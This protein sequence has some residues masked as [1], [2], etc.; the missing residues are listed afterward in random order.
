MA[1]GEILRI[2][3]LALNR[4]DPELRPEPGLATNQPLLMA[5]IHV[6]VV[7][8]SHG[9]VPLNHVQFMEVGAI[10]TIGQLALNF[11][12]PEPRPERG[13]VTNQPLLMAAIHVVVVPPSH[14]PVP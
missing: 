12:D 11:V 6:V 5:A 2:G 7:L 10:S 4:V 3:L 13:L 14:V 1:A 8:P 9:P